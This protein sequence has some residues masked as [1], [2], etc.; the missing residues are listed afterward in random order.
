MNIKFDRLYND[1]VY[2]E[3]EPS[4]V[5]YLYTGK[6]YTGQELRMIKPVGDAVVS[7][8]YPLGALVISLPIHRT[9]ISDTGALYVLPEGNSNVQEIVWGEYDSQTKLRKWK[10]KIEKVEI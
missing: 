4:D 5:L 10:P 3:V 2:C 1:R 7:T 6:E 8:H 9:F